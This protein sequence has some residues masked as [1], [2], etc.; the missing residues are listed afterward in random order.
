MDHKLLSKQVYN[1]LVTIIK[2]REYYYH[3]PVN[4]EYNYFTTEGKE[5]LIEWFELLAPKILE[6]EEKNLDT[7]IKNKV[8]KNL[9][10]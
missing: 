4:S 5:A 3:S 9:K 8:W 2:D 10:E 1:S 7:T 6:Q